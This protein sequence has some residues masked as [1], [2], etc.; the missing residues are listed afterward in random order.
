MHRHTVASHKLAGNHHLTT[1]NGHLRNL[2]SY[3]QETQCGDIL[4]PDGLQGKYDSENA[5]H[6]L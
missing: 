4:S 3:L 6:Y 1:N 5:S 2:L